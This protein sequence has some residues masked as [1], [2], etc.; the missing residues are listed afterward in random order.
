MDEPGARL[1]GEDCPQ[2]PSNRNRRRQV[3]FRRREGVCR[4]SGF[5]EEPKLKDKYTV[6]CNCGESHLQAKEDADFGP[7]TSLVVNGINAERLKDGEDDENSRPTVV[8]RERQVD[9]ELV[10]HT[11]RSVMFLDDVV[12][13]RHSGADQKSEHEGW[14]GAI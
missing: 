12:D 1:V 6:F 13:V 5:E 2:T 9:E 7:N 8:Q 3:T 4:S 14:N 10:R 11:L